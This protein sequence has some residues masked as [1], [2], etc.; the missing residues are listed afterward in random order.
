MKKLRIQDLTPRVV[1]LSVAARRGPSPY[2]R[3]SMN[4]GAIRAL[5]FDRIVSFVADLA[6][7]PTG[8]ERLLEL[9]PL[10]DPSRVAA[11][12]RATSEGARALADISGFPLRAPADLMAI[13]NALAVEGRALEPLRLF[14]LADYLESIEA[15]RAT[16]KRL[17]GRFPILASLVDAVASFKAEIADVRRKIEPGGDVA[18]HASAALAGI[19]DRLRRQRPKLRR[20]PRGPH[21]HRSAPGGLH[22]GR[23][24]VVEPDLAEQGAQHLPHPPLLPDGHADQRRHRRSAIACKSPSGQPRPRPKPGKSRPAPANASLFRVVRRDYTVA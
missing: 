1:H 15:T 3:E 19:R 8:H 23:R 2:E 17:T 7:T 9:H 12:Q 5:E 14:G 13:L 18:D 6:V 22:G 21:A 20:R 24:G 11:A 10:T 4:P 16:I